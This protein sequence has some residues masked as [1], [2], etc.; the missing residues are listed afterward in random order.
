MAQISMKNDHCIATNS[1]QESPS[2]TKMVFMKFLGAREMGGV[3]RH[4]LIISGSGI[5]LVWIRQERM[6]VLPSFH[7]CPERQGG[8]L[9]VLTME[10]RIALSWLVLHAWLA[11]ASQYQCWRFWLDDERMNGSS[12]LLNESAFFYCPGDKTTAGSGS[13]IDVCMCLACQ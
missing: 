13:E 8:S 10:A 12:H 1:T 7:R 5:M 4:C 11:L 6:M 3:W 9:S 2:P